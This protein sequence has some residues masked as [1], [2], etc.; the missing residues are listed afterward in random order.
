MR[1]HTFL[2][3]TFSLA[4][5]VPTVACVL[6]AGW[7]GGGCKKKKKKP[8]LETVHK[9]WQKALRQ[10][11]CRDLYPLLDQK[12]HWAV[13]S[14]VRDAKKVAA[15]VRRHYP[16]ARRDRALSHVAMA[17]RA[18]DGAEWLAAYC[19]KHTLCQTFAA[20][21]AAPRTIEKKGDTA[22]VILSN[23]K[24][25]TFFRDPWKRWGCTLLRKRLQEEQKR[26][27]NVLKATRENAAL[28]SGRNQ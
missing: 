10:K 7:L 12:S 8:S 1:R 17:R 19:R 26:M 3:T 18:K 13:L 9:R 25:L 27:A 24:R 22:T 6:T 21:A 5:L 20:W 15:L 4:L 2:P 11:R 23:G 28:F 16:P 14:L